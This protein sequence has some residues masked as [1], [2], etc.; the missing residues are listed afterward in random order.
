MLN[1]S[2]GCTEATFGETV[3][4]SFH[5]HLGSVA[6]GSEVR[7]DLQHILLLSHFEEAQENGA[8]DVVPFCGAFKLVEALESVG[9]NVIHLSKYMFSESVQ[10]E[11]YGDLIC[12]HTSGYLSLLRPSPTNF[13][14]PPP[15]ISS[16]NQ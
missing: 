11:K 4:A 7:L 2:S 15:I 6:I 12:P 13:A 10:I 5:P 16:I 14:C 8:P 1:P 3:V 9:I